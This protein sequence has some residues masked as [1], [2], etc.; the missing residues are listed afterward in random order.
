M[1]PD[2]PAPVLGEEE[3][4]VARA[5]AVEALDAR[6]GELLPQVLASP[7]LRPQLARAAQHRLALAE[8]RSVRELDDDDTAR[9]DPRIARALGRWAG[10]ASEGGRDDR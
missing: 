7:E 10:G 8:N 4:A 2:A 9:L 6:L 1:D 3:R 5:L